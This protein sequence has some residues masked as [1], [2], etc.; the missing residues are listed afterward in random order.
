MTTT[1]QNKIAETLA[2]LE[3][4]GVPQSLIDGQRSLY[5]E[6]D[7]LPPAEKRLLSQNALTTAKTFIATAVEADRPTH[8]VQGLLQFADSLVAL[9]GY[10]GATLREEQGEYAT[11]DSRVTAVLEHLQDLIASVSIE[12]L[13][14]RGWTEEDI[15]QG[16]QEYAET[17]TSE[18]ADRAD[19]QA[20]E[21]PTT[22]SKS[23]GY[24]LYL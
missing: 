15:A 19:R 6:I 20:P 17:G 2:D 5:A 18:R 16:L 1:A 12:G 4:K 14:A 10:V 22:T 21:I 11:G 23:E 13:K 8:E 7:A 24:G 9:A 3:G